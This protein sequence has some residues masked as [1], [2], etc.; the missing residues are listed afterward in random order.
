MLFRAMT[1][2]VTVYHGTALAAGL[3]IKLGNQVVIC[4][5]QRL[6]EPEA[7]DMK[8]V[9]LHEDELRVHGVK[10]LIR[11]WYGLANICPRAGRP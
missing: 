2:L 5:S 7:T 11:G 4:Q 3:R 6:L 1:G 8:V 10:W 9:L